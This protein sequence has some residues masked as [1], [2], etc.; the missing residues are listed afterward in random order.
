MPTKNKQVVASN[1]WTCCNCEDNPEF[2]HK[3]M[4]AHMAACHG[5][6]SKQTKGVK[7][8]VLHI[9]SADHYSS[10]YEWTINGLK[11]IQQTTN[12]RK[13]NDN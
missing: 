12:P 1:I 13:H 2:E 6:D 9:D 3:E 5:I 10:T 7:Q 4:M 8:M 11:F